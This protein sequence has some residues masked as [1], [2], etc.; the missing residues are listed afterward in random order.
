MIVDSSSFQCSKN[1]VEGGQKFCNRRQM[2]SVDIQTKHFHLASET[3]AIMYRFSRFNILD[4][5]KGNLLFA[6]I[7]SMV[8]TYARLKRATK[9]NSSYMNAEV[10][11]IK[12]CIRF[13]NFCM[14]HQLKNQGRFISSVWLMALMQSTV[15]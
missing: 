9:N 5:R 7:N 10:V 3:T 15:Q 11:L 13:Y 12:F 8:Y 4:R 14:P 1:N 6:P 2:S